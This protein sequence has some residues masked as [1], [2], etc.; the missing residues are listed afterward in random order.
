MMNKHF[1]CIEMK[2]KGAE[3]IQNKISAL[4]KAQQLEFWQDSS[5]QLKN[6]V[7]TSS[8]TMYQR[9]VPPIHRVNEDSPVI[10]DLPPH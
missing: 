3:F 1:D 10:N 8:G 7:N 6:R 5:L 2:R 9:S 4:T